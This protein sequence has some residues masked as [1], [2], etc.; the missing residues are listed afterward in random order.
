MLGLIER[1]ESRLADLVLGQGAAEQRLEA[2]RREI[3]EIDITIETHLSA[4]KKPQEPAIATAEGRIT[5][6]RS[7]FRGRRDIYAT[8]FVSTK[9]GKAGYAP[10]CRNKWVKGLCELPRVKCS[11]CANQAFLPPDDE[12]IRAHLMG[13]HVLGIYPMLVDEAC[14]FLAIDFDKS[15]WRKDVAALTATCANSAARRW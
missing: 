9:T 8:R 15:S 11:E 5:L 3:H 12:A 4:E 2:L 14:W 10:A 13:Q 7:L 1:E 6:F